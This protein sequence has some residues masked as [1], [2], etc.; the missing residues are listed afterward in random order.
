MKEELMFAGILLLSQASPGPDQAFC[1]P[2]HAGLRLWRG[3]DGCFGHW[4][5]NSC[6][7]CTGLYSRSIRFSQFPGGGA[8]LRR[9]LLDAVFGIE[10]MAEGE[11][12]FPCRVRDISPASCIY[13]DALVT[14]LMNP[15][16]TFF[17]CG[18]FRSAVGKNHDPSDA[19]FICFFNRG[20]GNGGLDFCGLLFFGGSPFVPFTD[21]MPEY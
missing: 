10:N 19:L 17:F 14:N 15:K 4:Y 12:C 5:R 13:R 11:E 3:S 20:D 16:A 9:F 8:V 1:Y 18:S 21:G 7:C 2:E 6:P